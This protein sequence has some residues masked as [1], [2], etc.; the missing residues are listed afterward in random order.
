MKPAKHPSFASALLAGVTFLLP[1][2]ALA[3]PVTAEDLLNA[4]A[5]RAEWIF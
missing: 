4:D 2:V 5:N 1:S 3:G